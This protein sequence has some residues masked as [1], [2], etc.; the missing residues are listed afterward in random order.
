MRKRFQ[1]VGFVLLISIIWQFHSFAQQKRPSNA[2]VAT[3]SIVKVKTEQNAI[4][5]LDDVRRGTTD[6]SGFLSLDKINAG[7]HV[8][9]V[10]ALGF[11]EKTVPLTLGNSLITVPLIRTTD[12]AELAFQKAE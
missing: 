8:L 5:W 2:R 10:R 6:G 12:H 3:E 1:L 9:R 7:R 4:V 11:S